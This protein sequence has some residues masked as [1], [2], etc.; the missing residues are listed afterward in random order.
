MN[1]AELIAQERARQIEEECYDAVHDDRL[2]ITALEE[3]AIAYLCE[4]RSFFVDAADGE[5]AMDWWPWSDA[6][7]K[8]TG[9]RLRDLVKAGALV[10]A[11][12]DLELR[13][14]AV[15]DPGVAME[16]AIETAS[17]GGEL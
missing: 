2:D 12:I 13:D 16:D 15:P 17:D 1:G 11:A 7:W 9:H 3:A 14:L 4:A 5:Q 6:V 8:P 10:A